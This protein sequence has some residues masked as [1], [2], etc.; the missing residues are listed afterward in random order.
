LTVWVVPISIE[1]S[2]IVVTPAGQDFSAL[3]QAS[4]RVAAGLGF[5]AV[6]ACLFGLDPQAIGLVGLQ[7]FVGWF[8]ESWWTF[9]EV[10]SK[11]ERPAMDPG[12]L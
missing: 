6:L 11:S 12:T 8:V 3:A 4:G 7:C 9:L 1:I 5:A 10:E 2:E